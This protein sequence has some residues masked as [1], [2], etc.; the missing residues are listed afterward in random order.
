MS[1]LTINKGI[2][3]I[4]LCVAILFLGTLNAQAETIRVYTTENGLPP[5]YWKVDTQYKGIL[6]DILFGLRGY[7]YSFIPIP[8]KRIDFYFREGKL[9]IAM[10]HPDY[11]EADDV[12][13]FIE[14]GFNQKNSLFTKREN[15]KLFND[16]DKLINTSICTREGY[17]YLNLQERWQTQSIRRENARK[18]EIVLQMLELGRCDLAIGSSLSMKYHLKEL[19]MTDIVETN[20]IVD[21]V[22]RYFAIS[23]AHPE[24]RDALKDHIAKIINNG[25]LLK[26]IQ[27]YAP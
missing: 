4:F 10:L 11:T 25:D 9:D 3:K 7:S 17:T 13:D 16:L 24:F 12:L 6:P 21:Q 2:S 15:E 22:P 26:I 5:F 1:C 14:L 8:R 18:D 27:R 19:N 20:I 23:K